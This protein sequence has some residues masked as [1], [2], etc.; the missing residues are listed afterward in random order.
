MDARDHAQTYR[1]YLV[2]ALIAVVVLTV[3]AVW[4]AFVLFDPTPPRTIAMATDPE[5][6]ISAELGKRY[7]QIL[8]RYGI[9]VRLVPSVGAVENVAH[10]S[11]PKSGISVGIIPSGITN[12]QQSPEL[13]SLGTLFYEPLWF[14][15]HATHRALRH[16]SLQGMR[17]SVGPEGSGTHTLSVEFLA[18]VGIIDQNARLLPLT[19]QVAAEKLVHGEIDAMALLAAWESP[20]VRQLLAAQDVSLVSVPRADVF[21]ALYPFLSKV[22]LPA[23]VG[24]MVNNRPPTDV[25]LLA[26]KA[27]LV[28]RKD[29]HPAIQYLLL[30]AATAIHSGPG[31]FRKAGQFPAAESIDLPLSSEAHRFYKAGP[32]F[33][34]RHLPFWLAVL[35]Q[36]LLVLLIPVLAVLYPLLRVLP[37]AYSWVM[38]RRVFTLYNEL[39]LLEDQMLSRDAQ[40]S[41]ADL[42]ARLDRLEER[43]SRFRLPVSFR[44]LLYALRLHIALV[45]QR[46]REP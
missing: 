29:L 40:K 28:V 41:A 30:E 4:V 38:R 46:L 3:A 44:P 35:A 37:A 34:Q 16:E 5:G 39:K 26:P 22:V 24:D 13:A 23:G 1:R 25:V 15:I 6:S 42:T 19:A 45:R 9:E 43:A 7:Q 36:Q 8:A 17:I 31:I 14:F 32:P 18:R 12:Q 27:S 10:L 21:V 20:V 2:V 11:D 33:L